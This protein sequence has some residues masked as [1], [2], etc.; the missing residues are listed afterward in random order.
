MCDPGEKYIKTFFSPEEP[1]IN[2]ENWELDLCQCYT[3]FNLW[4]L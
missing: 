4:R 2:E 1:G 3:V